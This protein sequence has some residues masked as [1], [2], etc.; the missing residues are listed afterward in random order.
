MWCWRLRITIF[1]FRV[2]SFELR[3]QIQEPETRSPYPKILNSKLETRNSKLTLPSS[4]LETTKAFLRFVSRC[5]KASLLSTRDPLP[6][7]SMPT[8]NHLMWFTFTQ[9][10]IMPASRLHALAENMVCHTSCGL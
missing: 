7:G 5:K 9:Y 2:S 8:S 3:D 1:Q 6:C 4:K 10:S